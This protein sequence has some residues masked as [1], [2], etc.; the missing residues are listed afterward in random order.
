MD[1]LGGPKSYP[2]YIQEMLD[3]EDSRVFAEIK[4]LAC[5]PIKKLTAEE[6][7]Q[8]RKMLEEQRKEDNARQDVESNG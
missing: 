2:G 7:E 8:L 6:Q 1:T 5:A 4:R 3:E